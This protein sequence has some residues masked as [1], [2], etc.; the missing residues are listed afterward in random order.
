LEDSTFSQNKVGYTYTFTRKE[1]MTCG[2]YTLTDG[3]ER[4]SAV[5]KAL[6]YKPEAGVRD[7]MRW[8]N[9]KI[10]LVLSAA[11]SKNE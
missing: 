4:G 11:S 6:C 5:V 10:Y 8:L 7:P 1:E 9:F 3:V 2:S